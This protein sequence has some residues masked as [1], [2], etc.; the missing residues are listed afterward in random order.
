MAQDIDTAELK[1]W[2]MDYNVVNIKREY[3]G[4]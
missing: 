2:P 1:L 4:F 3:N